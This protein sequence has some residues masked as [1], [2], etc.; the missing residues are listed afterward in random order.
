MNELFTEEEIIPCKSEWKDM[1]EYNNKVIPDAFITATF[2]FRNQEDYD[3]FH[4]IVKKE[5]YNSNKVFDGMQSKE[6]KQAWFPLNEKASKYIY[7]DEEK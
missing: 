4:S 2:K 7:T 1:P 3:Y 6:K 5:L